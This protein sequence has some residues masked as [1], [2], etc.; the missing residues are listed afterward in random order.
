V[1]GQVRSGV[2]GQ[3]EGGGRNNESQPTVRR[4]DKQKSPVSVVYGNQTHCNT[5]PTDSVRMRDGRDD[6]VDSIFVL[7]SLINDMS[8]AYFGMT[9]PSNREIITVVVVWSLRQFCF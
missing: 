1:S 4:K 5:Y 8:S 9:L 7:S 3:G 6:G 2:G